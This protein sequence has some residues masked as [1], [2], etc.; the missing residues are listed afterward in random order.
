[1]LVQVCESMT[2]PQTSKREI[3]A[4]SEAM[5]ELNLKEGTIV[6]GGENEKIQLDSGT[7]NVVPAWRFLLNLSGSAAV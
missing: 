5:A 1:M 2:A 6:T 3:A 7:I 4:L